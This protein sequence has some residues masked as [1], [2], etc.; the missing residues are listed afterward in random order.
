MYLMPCDV[1]LCDK[2][3]KPDNICTI[4]QIPYLYPAKSMKIVFRFTA[5]KNGMNIAAY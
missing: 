5:N 4:G 2:D 3:K 1:V